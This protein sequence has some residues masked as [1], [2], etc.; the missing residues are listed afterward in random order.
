VHVQRCAPHLH[1]RPRRKELPRQWECQRGDYIGPSPRRTGEARR[2]A[3]NHTYLHKMVRRIAIRACTARQISRQ[4]RACQQI[5]RKYLARSAQWDPAARVSTMMTGH[6]NMRRRERTSRIARLYL[7][8][9]PHTSKHSPSLNQPRTKIHLNLRSRR[10]HDNQ[11]TRPWPVTHQFQF[12]TRVV[13]KIH[14]RDW[15]YPPK[16][17]PDQPMGVILVPY[18]ALMARPAAHSLNFRFAISSTR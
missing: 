10:D 6:F 16:M 3:D 2:S 17:N 7:L 8:F 18:I 15:E 14:H 13:P 4:N 9:D 5:P 12:H 11:D 1:P